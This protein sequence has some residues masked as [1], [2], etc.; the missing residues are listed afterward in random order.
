M[1]SKNHLN[2]HPPVSSHV[3]RRIRIWPGSLFYPWSLIGVLSLF[4]LIISSCGFQPFTTS[5]LRK[6]CQSFK[7]GAFILSFRESPSLSSSSVDDPPVAR[8]SFW[9]P[10]GN[11]KSWRERK[12]LKDLKF[13]QK[14]SGYVVG[15][16]LDGRTG[17]KVF[18]ECG[19]GRCNRKGDWSMV[20]A[21]LRLN[22]EK[23]SVVKKRVQRLRKQDQ[24]EVFVSRIQEGCG[25]LEVVQN[26]EDLEKYKTE[27]KR[28]VSTLKPGEEVVGT[29]I[30]LHPYGAMVDIGAN[31]PGL[32]HI[33]KVADLYQQ[34]IKKEKGL[35]D[36]GLERG[37]KVRLVV[38]SI[39]QRRVSLDFTT[40]V[41]QEG[42]EE[43][44]RKELETFEEAESSSRMQMSS[45]DLAAWENFAQEAE[46]KVS[47][48]E[49][50]SKDDVDHEHDGE[51]DDEYEYDD[52]D[53]DR[54]IEDSLGLD[55]Y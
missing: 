49:E 24:I 37:A 11:D 34:Y 18:I 20:N 17:P 3:A 32:L 55:T 48:D 43:V 25:R 27:K 33:Q 47:P 15:E 54:A 6:N 21:M 23:A 4:S 41:K 2:H 52:Y 5:L 10:K 29:V 50:S 26:A 16:L 38:E 39:Q 19:V 51:Y 42:A 46:A 8:P 7:A 28:T 36:S 1:V 22:R 53:E 40:D 44:E 12:Q 13:G 9:K 35:E 14:L 31:R 45:E 30:K